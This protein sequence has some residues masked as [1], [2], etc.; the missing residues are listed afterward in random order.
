MVGLP[1]LINR[2]QLY[3]NHLLPVRLFDNDEPL[4]EYSFGAVVQ[5][6]RG[7]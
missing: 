1:V 4:G 6:T 5:M 2:H 3:Y 7:A